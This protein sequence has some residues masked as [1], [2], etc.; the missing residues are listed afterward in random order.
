MFLAREAMGLYSIL[1]YTVY[2]QAQV[3][4]GGGE[5]FLMAVLG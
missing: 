1:L 3:F 2:P 4:C 5:S